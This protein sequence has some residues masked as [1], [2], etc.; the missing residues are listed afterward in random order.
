MSGKE[1][2]TDEIFLKKERIFYVKL[3]VTGQKEKKKKKRKKLPGN[4]NSNI[5]AG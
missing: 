4:I 3:F 2:E 5:Y 1:S